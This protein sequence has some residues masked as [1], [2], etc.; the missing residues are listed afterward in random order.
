MKEP[1]VWSWG[2]TF[3][4]PYCQSW[5]S[6]N[7]AN[8]KEPERLQWIAGTLGAVLKCEDCNEESFAVLQSAY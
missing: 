6:Y 7:P 8:M 4:C 1:I 2:F 3:L 5:T